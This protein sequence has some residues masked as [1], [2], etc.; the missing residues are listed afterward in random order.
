VDAVPD[1]E[2]QGRLDDISALTKPDFS[3]WPPVQ[4]FEIKV[5]LDSSDPRLRPG[6][7]ANGRVAVAR[8][9]DAVTIPSEAVFQRGS[10]TVAYVN[11]GNAFSERPIEIGMR[12]AER[13]AVKKGL[14][15]GEKVALKDPTLIAG[16]GQ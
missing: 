5:V 2:F 7:S 3:S 1:K 8:Q 13:V 15:P 9:A 11:E 6:M 10:Q 12:T 4:Y 16:G 14:E